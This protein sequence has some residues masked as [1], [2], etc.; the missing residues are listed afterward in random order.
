MHLSHKC[1]RVRTAARQC[2]RH[3]R[4]RCTAVAAAQQQAVHSAYVHLPFCKRKCH[5]CDFSVV[6]LGQRVDPD[7]S[8]AVLDYVRW[9]V[10]P[11]MSCCSS[12]LCR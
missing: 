6:A 2:L 10:L 3:A 11:L 8:P 4:H 12:Q 9:A 5:Y 1:W 7:T